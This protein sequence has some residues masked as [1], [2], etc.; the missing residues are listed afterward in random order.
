MTTNPGNVIVKKT[1]RIASRINI[2][3]ATF[4]VGAAV[5]SHFSKSISP[6]QELRSTTPLA[7]SSGVEHIVSRIT[8]HP[9]RLL[10]VYEIEYELEATSCLA[11]IFLIF[12]QD[13]C[14]LNGH[15]S[16]GW[17]CLTA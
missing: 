2:S 7:A 5:K 15:I 10:F 6:P 1:L 14:H 16:S 8:F 4:Y 11:D 3:R 9:C 13:P 12:N 17:L